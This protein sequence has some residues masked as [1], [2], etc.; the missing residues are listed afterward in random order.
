M[1]CIRTRPEFLSGTGSGGI[2]A[3]T[4]SGPVPVDLAGTKPVHQF[5][6]CII[7]FL[8][9]ALISY[10]HYVPPPVPWLDHVHLS[11]SQTVSCATLQNP[12]PR[13]HHV[14]PSN[15]LAVSRAPLQFP[16]CITLSRAPLQFPGWIT[17]TSRV[18]RLY[19]ALPSRIQILD[20][21]TC[22]PPI[23]WLYHA[24]T[25][26]P[27]I[28]WLYH[29]ITCSPPVPWLDH[30]HLS[31]SQTVSCATLQNPDPRLYHVLPS[32]SLAVSRYHVLPSNF[33]GTF[34]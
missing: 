6:C 8:C 2:W 18:P 25:C 17:C 30:V 32:N 31:S 29:T 13:L 21:I 27:P 12:D 26:S 19:H 7:G 23:P 22:S 4:G 16:G 5:L 14:L 24:I 33:I 34:S 28:P 10:L 15:S 3:G 1:I 11:S 20:C 9:F